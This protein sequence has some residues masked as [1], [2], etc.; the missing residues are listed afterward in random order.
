MLSIESSQSAIC[1][2]PKESISGLGQGIY[3]VVGQAIFHGE[4][5]AEIAACRLM[6]IERKR[7]TH[8][9]PLQGEHTG[10]D[11]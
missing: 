7:M 5:C 2:H 11:P 1:S 8:E 10:R 4:V 6:W 3:L 9:P